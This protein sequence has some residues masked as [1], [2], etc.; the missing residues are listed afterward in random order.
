MAW[1][2]AAAVRSVPI[3]EHAPRS[4]PLLG[5]RE[6]ASEAT[7]DCSACVRR[8]IRRLGHF[9]STRGGK[10]NN[11]CLSAETGGA[12]P[13]ERKG[14]PRTRVAGWHAGE[15]P[16]RHAASATAPPSS[17]PVKSLNLELSFVIPAPVCAEASAFRS[18]HSTL[19]S[20]P[21]WLGN[22]PEAVEL[23]LKRV[24]TPWPPHRTASRRARSGTGPRR[25]TSVAEDHPGDEVRFAKRPPPAQAAL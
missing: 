4:R 7:D 24:A 5:S 23:D 13:L 9:P 11:C 1:V 10:A 20:E 15:S 22:V 21:P 6:H 16:S 2:G 3:A 18:T 8:E 17:A 14:R 19:R 12:S 25:G